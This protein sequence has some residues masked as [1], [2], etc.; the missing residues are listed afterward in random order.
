MMRK[1]SPFSMFRLLRSPLMGSLGMD[2]ICLHWHFMSKG[3]W[4][5]T[6][7]HRFCWTGMDALR[8]DGIAS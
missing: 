6:W 3:A 5:P 2:A 4:M 1:I 8:M 7:K